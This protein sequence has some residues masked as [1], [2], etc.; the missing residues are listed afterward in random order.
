LAVILNEKYRRIVDVTH[1]TNRDASQQ[2][3][4]L[5]EQWLNNELFL[6]GIPRKTR[7]VHQENSSLPCQK[8]R[9]Q[10]KLAFSWRC[11][12]RWSSFAALRRTS[13]KSLKSIF[14]DSHFLAEA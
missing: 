7:D 12:R 2:R 8:I 1:K 6:Y 5:P 4:Y 11:C 14:P 10:Q 13:S 9:R 3:R